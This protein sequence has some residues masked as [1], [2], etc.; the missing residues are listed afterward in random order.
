[1]L[2]LAVKKEIDVVIKKSQQFKNLKYWE[3]K[4]R[5]AFFSEDDHPDLFRGYQYLVILIVRIYIISVPILT[6]KNNGR[7]ESNHLKWK[8]VKQPWTDN[9]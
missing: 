4:K 8:F 6:G 3:E 7:V 9:I 2:N 5:R 1:M